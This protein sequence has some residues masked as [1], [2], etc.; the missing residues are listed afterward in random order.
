[1]NRTKLLL[2]LLGLI[3]ALSLSLPAEAWVAYHSYHYGAYGGSAS[4]SHGSVSGAHG[5][6]ASWSR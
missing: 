2:L 3:I 1:M 5:G 4:W 6:S